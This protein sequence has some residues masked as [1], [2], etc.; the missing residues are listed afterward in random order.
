MPELENMLSTPCAKRSPQPESGAGTPSQFAVACLQFESP[1]DDRVLVAGDCT[2]G[3]SSSSTSGCGGSRYRPGGGPRPHKPDSMRPPGGRPSSQTFPADAPVEGRRVKAGELLVLSEEYRSFW[4]WVVII[5]DNGFYAVQK[6]S[7]TVQSFSWT[8]FATVRDAGYKHGF[9]DV[10]DASE[11][12]VFTLTMQNAGKFIFGLSGPAAEAECSSWATEIARSLNNFTRRA[13]PDGGLSV[14]PLKAIF[15]SPSRILAGYLLCQP[16]EAPRDAVAQLCFCELHAQNGSGSASFDMYVDEICLDYVDQV[17]LTS[18]C[19]IGDTDANGVLSCVFTLGCYRFC[20]RSD[21]EKKLWLRALRNIR[22]KLLHNAPKPCREELRQYRDAIVDRA[23]E[24]GVAIDNSFDVECDAVVARLSPKRQQPL[25]DHK[26]ERLH[27][28]LLSKF[29]MRT[30]QQ[31]LLQADVGE[32]DSTDPSTASP[33]TPSSDSNVIEATV[34]EQVSE[35]EDDTLADLV[36]SP[37]SAVLKTWAASSASPTDST[38]SFVSSA[39]SSRNSTR[40]SRA[41]SSTAATLG[42]SDIGEREVMVEESAR[43]DTSM[44]VPRR[45]SAASALSEQLLHEASVELAQ[46][47][48]RELSDTA[49]SFEGEQAAAGRLLWQ[50]WW[51]SAL[52]APSMSTPKACWTN[53]QPT[54]YWALPRQI[55][56]EDDEIRVHVPSTP[57][58]SQQ[59][60]LGGPAPT[61]A[62]EATGRRDACS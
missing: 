24:L 12:A 6:G 46:L 11:Y 53:A 62:Q 60:Y 7:G 33:E 32:A 45:C 23:A 51:P 61:A 5:F 41:D 44:P 52:K 21:Q 43:I 57:R 18:T 35:A 30:V 40:E 28:H 37:R 31:R 58:R 13:L 15:G 3:G 9:D 47:C 59:D 2:G 17:E 10:E 27:Q 50:A 14:R 22:V 55:F 56:D 38:A 16:R 49:S 36:L 48:V 4:P 20:A 25:E 19:H 42:P 29:E 54:D 8:P 39:I 34:L 26:Q 1:G